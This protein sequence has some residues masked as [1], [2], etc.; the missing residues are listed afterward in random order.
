MSSTVRIGVLAAL[1]LVVLRIAIGWHFLYEGM[2]KYKHPEFSSEGF[3]RQARGPL[4]DNFH[5]LIPDFHGLQR[6]DS[7]RMSEAWEDY[8]RE[9]TGFY[10]FSDE[11]VAASEEIYDRRQK[12]LE[13]YLAE[14]DEDRKEYIAGLEKLAETRAADP[15]V[16]EVPFQQK[17]FHQKQTEL[18]AKAAPWLAEVDRLDADYKRELDNLIE[19]DQRARGTP[20]TAKTSLDRIDRLTT[21]GLMAIGFGLIVGLFTRFFSLAGAVFLAS[22]VLAQPAWPGIYPPLPPSAGHSLIVNKEFLEMLAL[23]VLA[24]TPVGRWAGLD[25]FI[26]HLIV[27]PCC[28]AKRKPH[29]TNA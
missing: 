18:R 2:W 11:Q 24:A 29:A 8:R 3:L 14:I 27:R 4:A 20:G 17:R 16:D 13:G 21:Y 6:L 28:S 10:K 7:Q 12:Q 22:I 23:L 26:H 25:F 5:G 15:T 9:L 1:L 19:S